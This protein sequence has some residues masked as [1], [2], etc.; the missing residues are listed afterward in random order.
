MS[1]RVSTG[2]PGPARAHV[3]R[4]AE[5][6][7]RLRH[8]EN[9]FRRLL[10]VLAR[11]RLGDP[12]VED[13][14]AP[15]GAQLDVG[16]LEVPVHDALAM[17]LLER[18]RHL[19]RDA[20]RLL[21]G[22]GPAAEPLGQRLAL[23]QLQHQV[24]RPVDQLEPVDRGD[25]RMAQRGEEPGLALE[26]AAQI[27]NVSNGLA[28]GLDRHLAAQHRIEGLVDAAHAPDA[29]ER[30]H[31]V[32]SEALPRLE[33]GLGGADL[34]R[35][36]LPDGALQPSPGGEH[37]LASL[38]ERDQLLQPL[39]QRDVVPACLREPPRALGG[40]M[41]ERRPQQRVQPREVGALSQGRFRFLPG[42][43]AAR[44][45]P[46]SS[47]VGRSAATARGRRRSP[48]R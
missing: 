17:G 38:G 25:A 39:A 4:G 44:P 22:Q 45:A 15:V 35:D 29:E 34:A 40:G 32:A 6:R 13:L 11:E 9:R 24:G 42:R 31:L 37:G 36:V 48:A 20:G 28:E 1:A 19:Q 26:A 33:A 46:S 16:R 27:G 14:H 30:L 12:E 41:I 18:L 10:V 7:S 23:H 2:S 5:D 3:R 43:P 47:P 21:E 8:R